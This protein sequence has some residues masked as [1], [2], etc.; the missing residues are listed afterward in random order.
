M[1]RWIYRTW[2]SADRQSSSVS[3]SKISEALWKSAILI[4]RSV[5]TK[6]S[7]LLWQSRS[8]FET[9][10]IIYQYLCRFTNAWVSWWKHETIYK[11]AWYVSKS[12]VIYLDDSSDCQFQS[13]LRD[14][15]WSICALNMLFI[16]KSSHFWGWWPYVLTIFHI[17]NCP[18]NFVSQFSIFSQMIEY[19][20]KTK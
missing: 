20:Q 11:K 7:R 16:R 12:W 3:I 6:S 17:S 18:V 14:D 9:N 10:A 1:I 13:V 2:H 15:R 19:P 4:N 8:L 5:L